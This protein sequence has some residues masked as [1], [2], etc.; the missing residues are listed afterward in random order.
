MSA[1]PSA[2]KVERPLIGRLRA[3]RSAMMLDELEAIAL[4]LFCEQ[5]FGDVTV[6]AI[7]AR[8]E[9]SARTFYRYFPTKEDVFQVQIDRRAAALRTALSARPG[10]EALLR[11]VRLGVVDAIG[12]EDLARTRLWTDAVAKSPEVIRSVMG[13]ILFKSQRAV[14]EFVGTRLGAPGDALTPTVVAAA[15]QAVIQAAQTQWYVEGGDLVAA[16]SEGIGILERGVGSGD[17]GD[18]AA[19]QG[20]AR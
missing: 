5:G 13:G 4:P 9:I 12:S 14:A 11:S 1:E 2:P 3:S 10:D 15:T 18:L 19:A 8:A 6:D 16:V 20:G 7:A 17:W